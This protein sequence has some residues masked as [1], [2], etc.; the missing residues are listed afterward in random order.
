MHSQV[1]KNI[2]Y[3]HK[4]AHLYGMISPVDYEAYPKNPHIAKF[5]VQMARAEDLGTGIRNVFH[6]SKLYSGKLPVFKEEDAFEV[7]IPLTTPKTTPKKSVKTRLKVLELMVENPLISK[8]AI[9]KTLNIS[10]E[11]IRYHIRI[12]KAQKKIKYE[13]PAKG[14]RWIVL[15]KN[16]I[17]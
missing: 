1:I 12:L 2:L 9:A 11:G 13:G 14:G 7:L 15:T 3:S 4:C 17:N 6:F 10:T 5:F 16:G 8:Q